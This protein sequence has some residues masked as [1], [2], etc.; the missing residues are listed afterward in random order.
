MLDGARFGDGGPLQPRGLEISAAVPLRQYVRERRGVGQRE[1]ARR[2]VPAVHH[3]GDEYGQRR[4]G[5][6]CLVC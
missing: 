1:I 3:D 4:D 6:E 2:L 5:L